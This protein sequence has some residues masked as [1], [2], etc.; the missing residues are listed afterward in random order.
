[1][2]S[3]RSASS[4]FVRGLTLAVALP[5][6]SLAQA[7]TAPKVLLFYDME[8]ISGINRQSQTMYPTPEYQEARKLLTGDVNAAIRGLKAAG[9]GTI[10]VTD[11]HGSGNGAEPDILVGQMDERA[12]FEFRDQPWDPYSEGPNA[13]YQ[14]IVC[15][16]MHA[17]AN[18]PGF[19]AHTYTIEP[20]FRVNGV[21]LT[22]TDII[23]ISAMRF[24]TPVIMV[25][26]DDV[27]ERQIK[28]HFPNAEYG[29]VKRA[30][31]MAD[32][33][34]LSEPEAR[35]NIER[36]AKAALA[37]LAT[38]KPYVMRAPFRFEMSFQ[39]E[40]QAE[41]AADAPGLTRVNAR[42][43]A[44]TASDFIGGYERSK[45]LISLAGGDRSALLMQVVRSRPDG[46]AILDEYRKRLIM[47]WIEPEAYA[48]AHP[49]PKVVEK[50]KRFHGDS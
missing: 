17:R 28:E 48:K 5:A 1:V 23:G 31:G 8:G 15:I 10:I 36:A 41:R 18:T 35:A 7:R 33:Q 27:L 26:G 43:L 25:S 12:T 14:A 47:R 24:G 11:A 4:A 45:E 19:L 9:A 37:K 32:A 16:G 34:L 39:N 46:Q 40:A 13:S 20:A 6:V 50:K 22:E 44:F 21:D 29:L 38:F 3:P 2:P 42:T 30:K 49:G